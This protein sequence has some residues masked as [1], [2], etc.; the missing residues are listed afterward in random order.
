MIP[1]PKSIKYGTG[2]MP[3]PRNFTVYSHPSQKDKLDVLCL[4]LGQYCGISAEYS[5]TE[6]ENAAF[7]SILKLE[8]GREGEYRLSVSA[9]GVKI[10]ASDDDGVNSA[11]VTLIN[12][13]RESGNVLRF[14][15]IED[16]PRFSFRSQLLDSVRHYFS[17]EYLERIVEQLSLLKCNHIHWVCCNDQAWRVPVKG[18]PKLTEACKEEC[19]TEEQIKYFVA[20]AAARGIEI[21]PEFEIPGHSSAAVEAYPELCCSSKQIK[22]PKTGGIFPYILCGGKDITY[23]FIDDVID[24]FCE[25]FPGEYIHIGGDEAPKE[26]WEKCPLCAAKIKVLGLKDLDELQCHMANYAAARLRE[27]GRNAV[28]WNET[29]LA[30]NADPSITVQYWAE[31]GAKKYTFDE[32]SASGREVIFSPFRPFYFDYHPAMNSLKDAFDAKPEIGGKPVKSIIGYESCLWTE[33]VATGERFEYMLF[34]MVFAQVENAWNEE[35]CWEDFTK[36]CSAWMAFL[37]T[38]AINHMELEEANPTGLR[39]SAEMA[40]FAVE[41]QRRLLPMKKA[42]KEI[43]K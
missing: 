19:Y 27:H 43:R 32:V 31:M 8:K 22:A 15:E 7:L 30:S 36:R 17:I 25:L 34:P 33:Q 6:D 35:R 42:E 38:Q 10:L 24:S 28:C 23:S 12:F 21:I 40:L 9:G 41:M 26:E 14:A 3:F 39:R 1:A 4:R 29:L 2:R 37:D 11:L 5:F 20:F 16:W 18:W 13:I